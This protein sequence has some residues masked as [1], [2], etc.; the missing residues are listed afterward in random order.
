MHGTVS[1]GPTCPVEQADEP[2]PPEPVAATVHAT[3]QSGEEIA[4]TQSGGDGR[5]SIALPPGRFVLTA[6]TGS[7]YPYCDPTEIEVL[8][9]RDIVAHISCD[10]GIR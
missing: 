5:Y 9:V 8:P 7:A 6:T 2:C 3:N 4:T 10:T 1:A